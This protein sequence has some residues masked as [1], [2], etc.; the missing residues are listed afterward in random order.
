MQAFTGMHPVP[1][2]SR[3]RDQALPS[4]SQMTPTEL[5]DPLGALISGLRRK[6]VLVL[7]D[8]ILDEYLLGDCTRISPEAPV[9][10]L[11]IKTSRQVLGGAANTAANIVSLGGRAT[12]IT[13]TGN[14]EGGAILR[15]CAADAGIDLR[16]V[17]HGLATLRKTRVVAHQQQIVRLDY[18]DGSA[19]SAGVQTAI[20]DV[21]DACLE[22]CDVVVISD[23]AKGFLTPFLSQAVI[24]RAHKA[25]RLVVVDPRPQNRDCYR[26]CDYLTPNWRESRAL[27]GLPDAA[28]TPDAVKDVAQ[29]LSAQLN[30]N[31]VLT[32]GQQGISFFSRDGAEQFAVPTLA[33][34]V[35]DVS[36]AGDTVVAAFSLAL[37]AGADH[38]AAI[39]LANRAAGVVVGKFGTATV[40]PEEILLDGETARLIPRHALGQLASTLRAKGKRIVTVNGSFDILHNGHLYILDEARQQGDVLIVGLN[41]DASVRA[42]KGP[43]R[44]IVPEGHRAD[45]LL[46]L[47]MVDYVHVFEEADPIAFLKVIQPD[48]HVNGS[49]YGENCIESETVKRGGG[50]IHIVGRLPDLSTSR[51]V[52]SLH[53]AGVAS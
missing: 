32:L 52:G 20:L 40:T 12:L 25:G 53:A 38:T 7:G 9:P 44:P 36:G 35:F 43:H 23:Y 42:Y 8:A 45:M 17:N 5:N 33:R 10:V 30:A 24:Q 48:V 47:R 11:Q 31:V 4:D 27:L 14:D 19:S 39:A 16:D 21:F 15:R 46:A 2:A 13:L 6:H 1:T 28:P 51:L 3:K 41:S 37:A 50:R 49:E 26:D 34:E 22:M 29:S 18:E